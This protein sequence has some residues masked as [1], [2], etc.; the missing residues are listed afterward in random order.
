MNEIE[1]RDIKARVEK[2]ES[3]D[4]W[5]NTIKLAESYIVEQGFTLSYPSC[6]VTLDITLPLKQL[7]PIGDPPGYTDY[8]FWTMFSRA[9]EE[10][11]NVLAFAYG[12]T[13]EIRFANKV[14][15]YLIELSSFTRWFEFPHRGSEGNLSNAHFTIGAAIG[16][17][18]IYSTL[19]MN[20]RRTIR[21]AIFTKGLQ[22]FIKDFNNHDSHNIIASKKVAMFIGSLAIYDSDNK[23]ELKP[24]L[25]NAYSYLRD[26]LDNRMKDSDIEG[27]LY[28]NVAARHILMAADI[29]YRSTGDDALLKH[30]YFNF[31]PDVFIY[32]LGT[33]GKT[34]FVNFSD[35][36]YSLDISFTMAI[37]ASKNQNRIA[38]WYINKFANSKLETL[39]HTNGIPDPTEP[40]IYYKNKN[41]KIF[42][43]IGWA[44]LRSGW[45][46]EDHLLAFNS[47]QSAKDHNHFDQN[48]FILHVAG[49]WLITNPGYQDYVE[50]SRRDFTIGT[51]GHNSMLINGVGQTQMGR[52]KFVEWYTSANFSY[53]IG[54]ATHA[55]DT[56]VSKWERKILHIDKSY[57]ILVDKLV[58]KKADSIPSFLYHTTSPIFANEK[59]LMPGEKT[60]ENRIEF[61]GETASVSLYICYP[62]QTIKSI[63]QYEG[64][65]E[66]GSYLS[67]VP[68]ENETM[69]Y[70]ITML[71]PEVSKSDISYTINS[72]RPFFQM[73]INRKSKG[74][75]DYIL[76]NEDRESALQI[77]DN[78]VICLHGEQGWVSFHLSDNSPSKFSLMNGS[79][80]KVKDKAFVKSTEEM[81]ISGYFEE[82]EAMLQIE[83]HKVTQILI[84]TAPPTKICINGVEE[85]GKYKVFYNTKLGL[86]EFNLKNGTYKVNLYF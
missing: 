18:A 65:E 32:M 37:L 86:L 49:D 78:E 1:I 35:S 54:D 57:F 24:F 4:I 36:F 7:E 41:A 17:D 60:E 3:S 63:E 27:L 82:A 85:K 48:N 52:S 5:K 42:S 68:S 25:L 29:F 81:N 23:D 10:R 13:K 34:S 40:E 77:T 59:I 38:S 53:V 71:V 69:H 64:A 20:E 84:K 39:I 22:P 66:Y 11:I 6:S 2:N 75:T 55:Y 80:L 15:A 26:Y 76:I 30:S 8:P 43:R 74:I 16:Y 61:R 56:S 46:E 62:H 83:L 79:Y 72:N 58:K 50:G 14:K 70:Q 47:S 28:L 45:K 31:L 21:D 73:Q 33:G 9:I 51:V 44:A 67:V 12:V 19:S